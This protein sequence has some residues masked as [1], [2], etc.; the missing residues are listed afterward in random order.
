MIHF[1]IPLTAEGVRIERTW[2]TLGLRA[3]G[4]HTVVLHDVFVPDAAVSLTR[5]AT[6]WHPVWD[7]VLGAAL[8]LIMAAYVGIADAAVDAAV[9]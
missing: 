1:G 6:E 8:P 7:T 2:D 3:T 5:S 9:D 4:S